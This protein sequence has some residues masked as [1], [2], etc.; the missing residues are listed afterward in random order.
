MYIYLDFIYIYIYVFRYMYVFVCVCVYIH[1]FHAYLYF[2]MQIHSSLSSSSAS[3]PGQF[4]PRACRP[5]TLQGYLVHRKLRPRRTLQQDHAQG[6]MVALGGGGL[7][8]MSEVIFYL[9]V[10]SEPRALEGSIL[11]DDQR[12]AFGQPS[13]TH[14]NQC[15]HAYIFD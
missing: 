7:C 2:F 1:T 5:S 9:R 8:L 3:S 12:A 15:M 6:R 4:R 11:Y 10:F 14:T 13:F